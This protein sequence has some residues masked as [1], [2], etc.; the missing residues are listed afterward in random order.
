MSDQSAIAPPEPGACSVLV[1]SLSHRSPSGQ[2]PD[3]EQL[4]A[5]VTGLLERFAAIPDHRNLTWVDHPLPAVLALCAGAVVAGM[6]SF[7]AI[8]GWIADAPERV[9]CQGAVERP[10]SGA[11]AAG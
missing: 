10:N 7:T 1:S 9:W 4:T 3:G 2:D 6:R 5:A 8:A 11:V